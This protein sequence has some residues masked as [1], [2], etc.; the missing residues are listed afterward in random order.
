MRTAR[1]ARRTSDARRRDVHR[2]GP[3]QS[4][5]EFALVI[6]IF[7]VTFMG[8]IEFGF[9]MNGQ[10]AI[11]YATR[12]S[13]LIAA[14]AG[15]AGGSDQNGLAVAADC[16]ILQKIEQDVTAPANPANITQVQIY[17]TDAYGNYL[18]TSGSTTT[19]GS[20]TQAVDTWVPGSDTC[21]FTDGSTLTVPFSLSGT[22]NYPDNAR[23]NDI[24]GTTETSGL[25]PCP[26]GHTGLDTIA[27]QVTY[28][29]TW[30]TPL[31]NFIGLLGNGWTLNQSNEMRMEPVL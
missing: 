10:L 12:D 25:A 9:L 4:L 6:P 16:V 18:S 31:H 29:D 19:A 14:E 7:L 2:R 26:A 23:C 15:N 1:L 13:A 28:H 24:G 22:A 27:V 5:V 8:V 11:N 20:S 30:R 17:W 21:T 3:G